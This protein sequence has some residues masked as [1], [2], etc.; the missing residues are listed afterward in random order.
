MDIPM[1]FLFVMSFSILMLVVIGVHVYRSER[2]DYRARQTLV[3]HLSRDAEFINEIRR[4][5]L[6]DRGKLKYKAEIARTLAL[7]FEKLDELNA[8]RAKMQEEPL[9]QRYL[10]LG[11]GYIEQFASDV[12]QT[13]EGAAK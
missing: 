8:S 4:L 2:N 7:I 1:I 5:R 11:T 13:A 12:M 6:G 3:L 9:T 10:S